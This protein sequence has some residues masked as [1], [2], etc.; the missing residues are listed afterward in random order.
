MPMTMIEKILAR[1]AGLPSVSPGDIVNVAVDTAVLI[2]LN[3]YHGY[4]HEFRR[5]WDPDKIVVVFDH[6]AP[7]KDIA[8]ADALK[9]G[10]RFVEKFGITRLHDVGPRL[11]ISHQII[12]D[13]AYALP[14]TVLACIDSHTCSAGAFNCAARG[15]GNPEMVYITAKGETWFRVAETILYRLVGEV[16]AGVSAKDIFLHL[17]GRFGDHTGYNVEF[18]G[19]GLAALSLN[20]RR[21][22]STMCCELSVEFCVFEADQLVVDHVKSRTS[23]AFEPQFTDGGARYVEK[24][25]IDLSE[26]EPMVSWPDTVI[27]NTRPVGEASDIVVDQAFIGSCANGT[28]DDFAIAARVLGGRKV[29]PNVKLLITPGSQAILSEAIRLGY[30]ETLMEAGA[31]VT[32]STCG[33]CA[34]LHLGVLAAGE[35]CITASTR[36]F[37]G[38]MGSSKADIY[39]GSP[40]TVAAS[41]IVGRIADPRPF[42]EGVS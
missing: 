11:G 17:A 36:N 40:A 7:P 25:Q 33:A 29:S 41:S 23:R 39:M 31:V 16:R 21:T 18:V 32:N 6:I 5:V 1:S 35:T 15:M 22:L 24:R 9:L 12:A 34:G 28:L 42:L 13:N 37:R 19:P 2:D 14:G 26:I 10:R 38:R 8:S 30:V 27:K 4:W 20:A 3:F